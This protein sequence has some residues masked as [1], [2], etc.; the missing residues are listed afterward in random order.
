MDDEQL[1]AELLAQETRVWQ[2]LAAGDAESDAA[3]LSPEFLGLYPSGYAD[4]AGHVAQLQGGPTVANWC[5]TEPR[6]L[7]FG[8]EHALLAYRAEYTR[9]AGGPAERMWV[10]SVWRRQ[11]DGWINL[12]SQDTPCDA[13]FAP[14]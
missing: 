12:F 8:P 2:A 5:L 7:R 6:V 14:V 3:A 9:P 4:R 1:L 13:P 11:G 10:S